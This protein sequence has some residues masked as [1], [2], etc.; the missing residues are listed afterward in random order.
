MKTKNINEK[1]S[2]NKE[3]VADLG[4]K[5]MGKVQGGAIFDTLTEP[6][7]DYRLCG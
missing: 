7:I 3:T 4:K 2:L 6:S 1:L 5:E